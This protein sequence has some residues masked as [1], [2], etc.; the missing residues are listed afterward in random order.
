MSE[1]DDLLDEHVEVHTPPAGFAD[2]VVD[3]IDAPAARAPRW[4]FAV[5]AAA[6]LALFVGLS[7]LTLPSSG[8]LKADARTS[9][10]IGGRGDAVLEAGAQIAHTVSLLGEVRVE[11]RAGSVFY[12][13]ERGGQFTV[14]TP[15]GSV[16]V[17]GTCFRVEV[18]MSVTQVSQ[19]KSKIISAA[20]GAVLASAVVVTVYEGKVEVTSD[21]DKARVALVAGE[22]ATVAATEVRKVAPPAAV[23][24]LTAQRDALR[25]QVGVLDDQLKELMVA[26]AQGKDPSEA[27]RRQLE[28]EVKELRA[29]LGTERAMRKE[30][31]GETF[32]FPEDLP[33]DYRQEKLMANFKQILDATGVK[34]DITAIDC[35]EYPCIVYGQVQDELP[36]QDEAMDAFVENMK[37]TYPEEDNNHSIS[38]SRFGDKKNPTKAHFGIVVGPKSHRIDDE[39][40]RQNL[41]RRVRYR[42]QQFMD[43]VSR[44]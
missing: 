26:K 1:F 25:E 44:E 17:R 7:P 8:D 39:D 9:V 16:H 32:T 31:E 24:E 41:H 14:D 22:S 33:A 13:V 29:Q 30:N 37:S 5:A 23:R 15:A 10:Q 18:P 36:G 20:V 12:R 3:A 40:A 21:D 35:N 11:Q 43:S 27:R 42:N 19:T 38:V 4:P 28:V 6:V 2:R 34:G